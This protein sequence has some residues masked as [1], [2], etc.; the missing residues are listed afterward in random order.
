MYAEMEHIHKQFPSVLHEHTPG[1][2]LNQREK[3]IL[4]Y[5]FLCFYR[6]ADV[7]SH[8]LNIPEGGI[9]GVLGAKNISDEKII[10][11]IQNIGE[12]S[13]MKTSELNHEEKVMRYFI[14][15]LIEDLHTGND[16]TTKQKLALANLAINFEGNIEDFAGNIVDFTGEIEVCTRD[17]LRQLTGDKEAVY[18]IDEKTSKDDNR[19]VLALSDNPGVKAIINTN[20]MHKTYEVSL[21]VQNSVNNEAVRITGSSENE[22]YQ[23]TVTKSAIGDYDVIKCLTLEGALDAYSRLEN[24]AESLSQKQPEKVSFDNKEDLKAYIKDY[25]EKYGWD[26]DLNHI[27][28]SKITDMSQL[29]M[30]T[31]FT[32]DISKWDVSNVRNMSHMFRNTQ[33]NGDLSGWNTSKVEDMQGMFSYSKFNQPIGNWDTSNVKKMLGMFSIASSI[34][35]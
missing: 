30:G 12:Y 27:D 20:D 16:L 1:V 17:F 26:A 21:P 31:I 24:V 29:F 19:I 22:N 7:M 10:S 4:N 18:Q 2:L 34:N 13:Q 28:V 14:P 23:Q 15:Q 11:Y 33:F 9:E 3:A 8:I 32:G 35:R 5:E 25:C 6:D